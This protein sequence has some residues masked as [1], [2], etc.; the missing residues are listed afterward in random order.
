MWCPVFDK[1]KFLK[2]SNWTNAR[3]PP[4]SASRL[5]KG[6]ETNLFGP[7]NLTRSLLPHFREKRRGV[8]LFMSSIGAYTGAVGAGT[9]SAT[10]GALECMSPSLPVRAPQNKKKTIERSESM[11]LTPSKR[12]QAW[13]T[14]SAKRFPPSESR[15]VSSRPA[16]IG[17]KSSRLP[18]SNLARPA[19]QITQNSTNCT[20]RASVLC[21][22]T[23][24]AIRGRR[25]I[26]S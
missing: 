10:K 24:R 19:F 5:L 25:R 8:I 16:T 13:W 15:P 17:R 7:I 18:I 11:L 4:C 26:V 2:S 20:K 12:Y 1:K 22:I 3:F 9:Y 6:F 21:T 23:N 14:V